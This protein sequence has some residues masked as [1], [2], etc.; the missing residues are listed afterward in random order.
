MLTP[1][2]LQL[3]HVAAGL[4]SDEANKC[5][6][7]YVYSVSCHSQCKTG[8]AWKTYYEIEQEHI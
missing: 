5:D 2:S 7:L 8:N 3:E 4:R 1:W 6:L